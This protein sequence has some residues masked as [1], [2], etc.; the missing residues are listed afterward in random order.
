MPRAARKKS[1]E[2]I[3]HIMARSI[4]EVDLFKSEDD[5]KQYMKIL[6]EYQIVYNFRVYAYCLMDNHVHLI[7]D[8]NGADISKIM[9]CINFKYANYFNN[10]HKRHGHLFQDRFKSKIVENNRYLI[11]L[12][13]YIHNNPLDIPKYKSQPEKYIYSS[14]AIYLGLRKDEF[15]LVDD[16]F[17]LSLFNGNKKRLRKW[18]MELVNRTRTVD[19][20]EIKEE[21]AEFQDEKTEYRSG[22]KILARNKNTED[23]VKYIQDRLKIESCLIH[24]KYRKD[25][26]E[27]KALLIVLLRNFCGVSCKEIC[28]ILGNITSSRISKLCSIGVSLIKDDKSYKNIINDF[29]ECN[30]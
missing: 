13:A 10:I 12:S 9:H 7:I 3:Y 18:Y 28:C 8:S 6:K 21:E 15:N 24:I 29:I 4:S 17:V 30:Y 20:E 16:R 22:R 27:A 26:I 25:M 23:V 19:I 11:S 14:L 1:E 2:A 5:K